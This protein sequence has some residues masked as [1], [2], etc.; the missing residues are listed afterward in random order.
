MLL[1]DGQICAV[2]QDCVMLG[3]LGSIPVWVDFIV[4]PSVRKMGSELGNC[5]ICSRGA[6][7]C[8]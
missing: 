3:R 1:F 6:L 4:D 5:F 2:L 7:T 8:A